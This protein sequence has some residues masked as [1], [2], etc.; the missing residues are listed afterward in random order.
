MLRETQGLKRGSTSSNGVSS[1]G[2]G[3]I[4]RSCF[5]RSAGEV[6]QRSGKEPKSLEGKA[7][8]TSQRRYYLS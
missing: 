4:I 6:Q 1:G 5:N 7:R 2:G 8:K 3:L